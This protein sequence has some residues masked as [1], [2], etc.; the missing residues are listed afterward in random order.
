MEINK[1]QNLVVLLMLLCSICG[2]ENVTH[3]NMSDQIENVFLQKY[4]FS[5]T[6]DF[7]NSLKGNS[8]IIKPII[9]RFNFSSLTQV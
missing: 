3:L 4:Q 8:T 5:D 6:N 2:K 9:A 7:L 1:C